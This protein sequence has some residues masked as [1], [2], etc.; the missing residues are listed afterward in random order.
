M[1]Y[2]YSE[3]KFRPKV[4]F[5]CDKADLKLLGCRQKSSI[6]FHWANVIHQ[7][8][9]SKYYCTKSS[10]KFNRTNFTTKKIYRSNSIYQILPIK[11]YS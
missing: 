11:F 7:I 2:D 6:K 5:S 1:L 4:L 8:L 9:P 10:M 3:L